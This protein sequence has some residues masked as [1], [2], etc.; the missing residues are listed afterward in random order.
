VAF[1]G[2]AISVGVGASTREKS[3]VP[4]VVGALGAKSEPSVS[5]IPGARTARLAAGISVPSD[6]RLVIIEAGTDDSGA[7]KTPIA[8][9]RKNYAALISKVRTAAPDAA[10]LC[11][12]VWQKAAD[13]SAYDRIIQSECEQAD[14][15]FRVLHDIYDGAGTRGPAG[16]PIFTKGTKS[17]AILPNDEGYRRIAARAVEAVRVQSTSGQTR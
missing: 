5:A 9:F 8:D 3:W 12:G 7:T 15:T 14:G 13:A 1:V 17:D 6:A 2:D 16:R 11:L 4:A 10:I